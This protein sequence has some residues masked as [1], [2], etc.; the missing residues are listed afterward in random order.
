MA[1]IS[2]KKVRHQRILQKKDTKVVLAQVLVPQ[3]KTIKVSQKELQV[4]RL[5]QINQVQ[6]LD[7]IEANLVEALLEVVA[8]VAQEVPSLEETDQKVEDLVEEVEVVV[9]EEEEVEKCLLSIL[10]SS[11]TKIQ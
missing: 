4:L 7:I 5:K 1:V 8:E 10:H 6:A 3:R 2:R 9:I 11:S